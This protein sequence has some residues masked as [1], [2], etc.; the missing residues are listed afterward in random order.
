MKRAIAGVVFSAEVPLQQYS[1][2]AV[3]YAAYSL[4]DEAYVL[5]RRTEAGVLV[6]LEPKASRD[7]AA[8]ERLGERFEEALPLEGIRSEIEANSRGVREAILRMA[9]QGD[10]PA[11]A[12]KEPLGLTPEQE[13][14]LDRLVADVETELAKENADSDPLEITQTWEERHG[15]PRTGG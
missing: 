4:M 10:S 12:P 9:I 14:E 11:A 3:K 7:P 6:R 15:K 1:P 2:E 13:A 5:L 8:P